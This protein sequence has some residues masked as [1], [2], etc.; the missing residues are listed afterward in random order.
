MIFWIFLVVTV[1]L[2]ASTYFNTKKED[3]PILSTVITLAFC[4][5][6]GSVG[7]MGTS[8]CY[9]I[10]VMHDDSD[11]KWALNNN[12]SADIQIKDISKPVSGEI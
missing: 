5:M 3:K 6:F 11:V 1:V 9:S 12:N 4:V 8:L 7:L 2:V 10:S